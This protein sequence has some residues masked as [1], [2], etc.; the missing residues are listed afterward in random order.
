MVDYRFFSILGRK[1]YYPPKDGLLTLLCRDRDSSPTSSRH[2]RS[3]LSSA[4]PRFT[5][6]IYRAHHTP[7]NYST[8]TMGT[9]FSTL[10]KGLRSKD[11][12][13][14]PIQKRTFT[15]HQAIRFQA[16]R[17]RLGTEYSNRK[18]A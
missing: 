10:R 3:K 2:R 11:P 13:S 9:A 12:S 8:K 1:S 4:G 16:R 6:F 5:N 14:R 15:H 17:P 7:C 18:G